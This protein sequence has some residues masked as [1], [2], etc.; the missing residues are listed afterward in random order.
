MAACERLFDGP[1]CSLHMLT[2]VAD[3]RRLL[4][5]AC[6]YND[7]RVLPMFLRGRE[8]SA[9]AKRRRDERSSEG[10]SPA[11]VELSWTMRSEL[12][13]LKLQSQCSHSRA[14]Q[15]IALDRHAPLPP[16]HHPRPPAPSPTPHRQY[17]VRS[18]GCGALQRRPTPRTGGCADSASRAPPSGAADGA[19]RTPA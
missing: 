8:R 11:S 9:E 19:S 16:P 17:R 4:G 10:V 15:T 3:C 1:A 2:S 13:I 12:R 18:I 5:R 6:P 14:S 7:S